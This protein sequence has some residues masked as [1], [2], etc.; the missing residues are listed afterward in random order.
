MLLIHFLVSGLAVFLTAKIVPGVQVRGFFAATMAAIAIG[1]A[2]ATVYWVLLFL[3]LPLVVITLGLFLFVVNA[4]VLRICAAL[5]PGFEIKGW[6]SAILGG[7]VLSLLN[8][9]LHYLLI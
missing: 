7:I 4:A 1:I 9:F 3:A 6:F 5:I 2:N 8:S